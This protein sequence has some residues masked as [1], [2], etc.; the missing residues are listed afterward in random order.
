M[1]DI[2]FV[3][4]S[5]MNKLIVVLG[6]KKIIIFYNPVFFLFS[7]V[8]LKT[9]IPVYFLVLVTITIP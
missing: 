1:G 4:E 8:V 5:C 2:M 6:G 9:K 7:L 3:D